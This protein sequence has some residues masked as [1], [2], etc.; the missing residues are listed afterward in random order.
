MSS[1][2]ILIVDDEKPLSRA[3]E[4]KLSQEGFETK[5]VSNGAEALACAEKEVFDLILLD[6][7][8]PGMDGYAVLKELQMRNIRIPVFVLSNLGQ[9]EDIEKTKKLGAQEFFVKSDTPIASI[10]LR[11][12]QTFL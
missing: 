1:K 2:K 7:I 5:V 4:L 8:M 3:L 12:K 10:V 6:L 9:Q 11:I